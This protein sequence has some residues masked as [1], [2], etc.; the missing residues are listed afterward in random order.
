MKLIQTKLK[1][2]K[3]KLEKN[4]PTENGRVVNKI[5]TN[6]TKIN[7]KFLVQLPIV[8]IYMVPFKSPRVWLVP[9]GK[10][11][12]KY[13]L[14]KFDYSISSCCCFY[15]LFHFLFC[16]CYF[17]CFQYLR[18]LGYPRYRRIVHI[19]NFSWKAE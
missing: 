17:I 11:H 2:N 8:N 19:N 6:E 4:W 15:F 10:A 18:R 1:L 7:A 3:I 5:T 12:N 9:H 13:H 16:S 14:N